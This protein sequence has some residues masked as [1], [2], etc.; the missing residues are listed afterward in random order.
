M[1]HMTTLLI[2]ALGLASCDHQIKF[3]KN[4]WSTKNDIFPC[5]CRERMMED[6][7]KN[8]K[9]VGLKNNEL[10]KILGTPD[11]KQDL[12]IQ[13]NLV[14]D[15]GSDIDPI[16]TKTLL[17]KLNSDSTVKDYKISEWHK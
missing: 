16:H 14:I 8:H 7:T 15:Y 1:R 6:L 4:A 17:F 3:D 12:N 2:L 10:M 13:Y 5:E 11:L 9:L